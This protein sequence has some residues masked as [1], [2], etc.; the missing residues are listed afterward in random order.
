[1]ML[2][3]RNITFSIT[4][5]VSFSLWLQLLTVL[6]ISV[7][8]TCRGARRFHRMSSQCLLKL[9]NEINNRLFKGSDKL[10]VQLTSVSNWIMN[11]GLTLCARICSLVSLLSPPT[12]TSMSN[13]SID[14][15]DP[16]NCSGILHACACMYKC[17]CVF[18]HF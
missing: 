7:E 3:C 1:M 10:G 15:W 18:D 4:W 11:V 8:F 17:V 2:W 5:T 13:C 14:S 12:S 6:L 16:E 9:E